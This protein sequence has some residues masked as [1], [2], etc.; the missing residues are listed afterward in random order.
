MEPAT[1][2]DRQASK[3][4]SSPEM[5]MNIQNRS[6]NWV[7][8]YTCADANRMACNIQMLNSFHRIFRK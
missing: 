5:G 2:R 7:A 8:R 1:D 6:G 4:S 3:P